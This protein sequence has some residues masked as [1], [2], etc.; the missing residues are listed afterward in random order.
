MPRLL[1][2][3]PTTTYRAD[4]F[5]TAARK[6][7]VDVTAASEHASTMA[8]ARPEAFLALPLNRAADA[9]RRA[10]TFSARYP[11]DGVIGVDDG[12][13]LAAAAIAEVLDLPRNPPESVRLARNKL[14][15]RQALRAAGLR[16]PWFDSLPADDPHPETLAAGA[17]YPCVLKPLG[18]SG[19]RG[20]IRA[21]DPNAF[22][23]AFARIGRILATADDAGA[24]E[25]TIL[26]ESFI[27]GRE[28]AIEAL[29]VG[30]LLRP[31]CLFD[32]PDP[33][34]GPYFEETLYVTPSRLPVSAQDAILDTVARAAAAL[35][36]REGP[37]HAEVRLNQDGPW[38]LEVNPRSIGGRCS[39]ALRF[40][41]AGAEPGTASLEE[42]I[43]RHALRLEIPPFE[44][45]R[46]AAGVMM[47]PIPAGGIFKEVRNQT[48]ALRTPG[49]EEIIISAHPGQQIQ[50]LPEGAPYLG[51]LFAR[52]DTPE[53]V[54][55]A[56]REAHSKLEVVII[57]V[58]P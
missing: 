9:A 16:S 55:A 14:L 27:P 43:I 4:E 10:A 49:V 3:L 8:R 32:K 1:L 19:G 2:L 41:A 5:L 52:G 7:G 44:R 46:A 34:D 47:L 23:A 54:E 38:V 37:L 18:L 25:R 50:T 20:V 11:L 29:L 42:I 51:F 35:G 58:A 30:G 53:S 33:L 39:R 45:E 6:L 57:P 22:I 17:P 26:V 31:L 24:E 40:V 56:L 48:A 21:D 15:A 36:L 12:S 28:V 13:V